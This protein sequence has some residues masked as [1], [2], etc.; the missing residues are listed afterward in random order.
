MYKQYKAIDLSLPKFIFFTGKGGVGKT[1][2]ACATA[3]TLADNGNK[4]LIVST[5]P[6]SN[7]QDVFNINLSSVHQQVETAPNLFVVNL[8]PE[9]AARKYKE[10]IVGPYRGKLP[11]VVIAEMEEKLSG[12]CTLEVSAFNEF[13]DYI[14][15]DEIQKKYDY[16][17]FD[18]A[19]T[20]HTLRLLEL[21]AAWNKYVNEQDTENLSVGQ[22]SGL[23]SRREDCKKAVDTLS[24]PNM[25]KMIL[26]SRAENIPLL[27]TARALKELE[28]LEIS[29]FTIVINGLVNSGNDS[30]SD[31]F[32]KKQQIALQNIPEE[33]KN[34]ETF[35]IPLRSYNISGIDNIRM[36]LKDDRIKDV[37]INQDELNLKGLKHL[38]NDLYNSKKKVVFTMGKGGVGKTSIAAAVALGL[39]E[40]GAKVHLT[41]TDPADHLQY[42]IQQDSKIT[43][44]KID[45][46]KVLEEYKSEV[47]SEAEQT[48]SKEDIDYLKE[49]LKT[50]CTQEIAV[51]RAFSK[52]VEKA[53]DEIVVIDTAPTGHTLLL[54]DSS[55]RNYKQIESSQVEVPNSV[56]KLLPRLRNKN[57]TEV[58]IVTLPEITPIYEA[59]RLEEDLKRAGIFTKWWV[60]NSSLLLTNTKNDLLRVK[61]SSELQWINKT[62]N[63]TNNNCVITPWIADDIKQ[64]ILHELIK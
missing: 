51:F 58:I 28:E 22:L 6:A 35:F 7:L 44:S 52:I 31:N 56:R 26:V 25:T 41:T 34:I 59:T 1:S 4:V 11:D 64:S 47:L 39:S 3:V 61:A 42:I 13:S 33:L 38:I 21:P 54:L 12:S 20:G 17:I 49:S 37:I 48:M 62:I 57:D 45:E 63:Y 32:Y 18:T 30:I 40:K 23:Q 24:D 60:I 43:L 36:M 9:E 16:I 53:D 55:E 2:T 46:K 5:D 8:N 27:E 14:T 50:P 29:N 19:P 10:S 15:N